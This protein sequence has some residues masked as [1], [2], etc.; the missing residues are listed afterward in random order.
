MKVRLDQMKVWIV[1]KYYCN[2][3]ER[4][5]IYATKKIALREM[6]KDRD[7]F[8]KMF[9][10]INETSTRWI[11]GVPYPYEDL[12]EKIKLVSHDKYKEWS[13]APFPMPSIRECEVIDK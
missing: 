8:L 4:I 11:H 5:Y 6:F 9:K 3:H 2:S 10:E 1:E 13:Y 7:N 12:K